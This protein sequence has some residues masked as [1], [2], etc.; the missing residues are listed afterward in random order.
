[1]GYP[2]LGD[3]AVRINVVGHAS[4]RWKSAK[5]AAE[6]DILN[7]R[8][9]E[10]RA[11]NALRAVE[12]ILKK[13]LPGLPIIVPSKGVGS[14]ER[15]PT[16]SEDNAAIDRSV[17]ITVELTTTRPGY[18]FQPRAPRRVYV[19]SKVW[20]LKVLS[21]VRGAGLGIVIIHL[22]VS[23][24]NP[25][26]GKQAILSGWLGGGGAAMSPKDSFKFDRN[27]P[28][29]TQVGREVSFTTSEALDF[30]DLSSL[31]ARLGK[32]EV[33]VL[34]STKH[35]YLTFPG[36]DTSPDMLFFDEK[37]I[38]FTWL[39]ADAYVVGGKLDR[40][41]PNP[42]DYLEL[43]SPDDIIPT[44]TTDR[45]N[46]GLL[47]S[48]PTGKA[49]LHNLTQKDNQDLREFVTNKARAIAALSE[50]FNTSAP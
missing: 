15:F 5:S 12:S 23:L 47:L 11:K 28:S 35:T 2:K 7:Q 20:T 25:Y 24:R 34:L 9:S 45:L 6:A 18:K 33:G 44:Q 29:L 37:W 19:P 41:G 8:L 1:M 43:P 50:S 36:L 14:H 40:E 46:D 21:M 16:A 31:T 39:K 3:L 13:E 49:E 10:A 32:V 42:G 22:K 38:G 26:T 4:P 48:F 30:D 17:L 27:N